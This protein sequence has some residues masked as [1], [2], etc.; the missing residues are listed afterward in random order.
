MFLGL[1]KDNEPIHFDL[2]INQPEGRPLFIYHP[3]AHRNYRSSWQLASDTNLPFVHITND[4]SPC[5][6]DGV[7]P[8]TDI[9]GA[10]LFVRL[11]DSLENVESRIHSGETRIYRNPSLK[12]ENWSIHISGP[13]AQVM[14]NIPKVDIFYSDYDDWIGL[15]RTNFS[16]FAQRVVP[17]ISDGGLLIYDTKNLNI[18][19]PMDE[20]FDQESLIVEG[21]EV[22][23]IGLAEW[24][25]GE[26]MEEGGT[27]FAKVYRISP[28]QGVEEKPVKECRFTDWIY[29]HRGPAVHHLYTDFSSNNHLQWMST[30]IPEYGL[31]NSEIQLLINAV[32][33][34]DYFPA[35]HIASTPLNWYEN[36]YL[37]YIDLDC[38]RISPPEGPIPRE[39]WSEQ[40]YLK[41]LKSL[42]QMHENQ[43]TQGGQDNLTNQDGQDGLDG[44]DNLTA[45]KMKSPPTRKYSIG[46]FEL[47]IVNAN[48]CNYLLQLSITKA[49]LAVRNALF[50]KCARMLPHLKAKEIV[51]QRERWGENGIRN[52]QWSG[53]EVTPDLTKRILSL[54]ESEGAIHV[55]TTAHGI[56]DLSE[57]IGQ[58]ERWVGEN[59]NSNLKKLTV[60]HL[61]IDDYIDNEH[62]KKYKIQNQNLAKNQSQ[63]QPQ[64]QSQEKI[65]GDVE[66]QNQNNTEEE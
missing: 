65:S 22:T 55:A 39:A 57:I 59:S 8:V 1:I 32:K 5:F 24:M 64:N 34:G 50:H 38:I 20:W 58:C 29:S 36:A 15:M 66:N 13:G 19:I 30:Y 37:E 45:R 42:V 4:F 11:G 25:W 6:P 61:D 48:I 16:S 43:A 28:R 10:E 41:F 40:G 26:H 35:R 17:Y 52:L 60:F 33:D 14:Q 49:H 21:R 31:T 47:N 3:A 62:T 54:G 63:N 27:S 23:L 44:Q 46:E 2:P 56:T 9:A 12:Q 53:E 51:I 7:F 18:D